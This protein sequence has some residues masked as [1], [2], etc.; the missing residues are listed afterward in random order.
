MSPLDISPHLGP[1]YRDH[2]R[3]LHGWLRRKLGCSFEA[4]DLTH[5]TFLRL[6][7]APP[8]RC[9][10]I[11]KPRSFLTTIARRVMVDHFRRQALER[12]YLDVLAQQPEALAPSPEERALL[13]ETLIEIDAMLDRLNPKARQ[14][15]LLSQLEGLSYA[16]IALRLD[17]SVSSVKKYMAK[18]IEH[19]LLFQHEH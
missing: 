1:L 18:A 19:C 13:L 5:D 3:F 14:A 8:E 15:F 4:A 17:V 16:D 12:A 6:L 11:A 7:M 9:A 2:H 10:D